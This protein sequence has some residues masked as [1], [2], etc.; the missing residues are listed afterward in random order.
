MLH[1]QLISLKL[2]RVC[3]MGANQLFNIL[4]YIQTLAI[5]INFIN[6]QYTLVTLKTEI[7]FT[8]KDILES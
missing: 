1:T 2:G 4:K 7:D 5:K 6:K 3:A 8:K